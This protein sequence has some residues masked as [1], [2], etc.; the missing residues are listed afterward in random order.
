MMQ[1]M[2]YIGNHDD[3]FLF[4][5]T[6]LYN[7]EMPSPQPFPWQIKDAVTVISRGKCHL[8]NT[9][10]YILFFLALPIHMPYLCMYKCMVSMYVRT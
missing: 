3:T 7:I 6:A 10:K 2:Y 1:Y 5:S 8:E 9:I 4:L